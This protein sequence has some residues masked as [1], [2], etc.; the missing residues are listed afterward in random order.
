MVLQSMVIVF[1]WS[2]RRSLSKVDRTNK[3]KFLVL[4]THFPLTLTDT[5]DDILCSVYVHACM[6]ACVPLG[7]CVCVRAC[8]R[9]CVGACDC[10]VKCASRFFDQ[11]FI[12]YSEYC[13]CLFQRLD[14][15]C[16]A[17]PCQFSNCS[18]TLLI[19]S[20]QSSL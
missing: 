6:H 17:L 11:K 5:F 15:Q 13:V 1:K 2:S 7:V 12:L 3:C 18:S 10:V 16:L 19:L 4:G 20:T 14:C 8:M 9:M